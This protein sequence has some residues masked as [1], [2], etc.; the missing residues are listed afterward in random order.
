[1]RF[2]KMHNPNL[3]GVYHVL[4]SFRL[5][6][7]TMH[8]VD[9]MLKPGFFPFFSFP[10]WHRELRVNYV[11]GSRHLMKTSLD[12]QGLLNSLGNFNFFHLFSTTD[13]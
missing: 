12:R 3:Y 5:R 4:M 8:I 7:V 13:K 11:I 6:P 1:M 2:V 10:S 9:I